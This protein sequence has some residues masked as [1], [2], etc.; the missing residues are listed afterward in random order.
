MNQRL[1]W[2]LCL[3]SF[4]LACSRELPTE[5]RTGGQGVRG[6]IVADT[7]DVAIVYDATPG[8]LYPTMRHEIN[9]VGYL[10]VAGFID[11]YSYQSSDVGRGLIIDYFGGYFPKAGTKFRYGQ[12][13]WSPDLFAPGTSVQYE[14]QASSPHA[15]PYAGKA[16]KTVERKIDGP[17][18]EPNSQQ[19]T[20]PSAH[21]FSPF[22]SQDGRWIYCY[23]RDRRGQ[24]K[25]IIRVPTTGGQPEV[26]VETQDN[27]GGFALTDGDTKLIFV[28]WKPRAKSPLVRR[29]LFSGARDTA[30]VDEAFRSADLIPI[31][32]TRQFISLAAPLSSYPYTSDLIL[33]DF[34]RK[35]VETL[36]DSRQAGYI[37]HFDFRPGTREISYGYQVE[38]NHRVIGTNVFLLN[39][40]TRESK[41][42]FSLIEGF[43]FSWAPNGRDFVYAKTASLS[44]DSLNLFL[45]ESGTERQIT[46]YP[47][48]EANP[49]FS[50]TSRSLAFVGWRRDEYQI[51]R[52]SF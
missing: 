8:F 25:S 30:M 1:A 18:P 4:V 52:I 41:N 37:S 9:F 29:D 45:R 15:Y 31:P 32:G 42:F 47:G 40:D 7:L 38:S 50:P 46:F 20:G 13:L 51:W 26:I 19:L 14:F 22:F 43:D 23:G 21:H 5:T 2:G 17:L 16:V 44:S 28:I 49:A 10:D 3:S 11:S 33:I 48:A 6:S 34:D 35:T 12:C 39:L 36:V 24:R 27:L